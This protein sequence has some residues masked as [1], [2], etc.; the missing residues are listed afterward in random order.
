MGEMLLRWLASFGASCYIIA[1]IVVLPAWMV[2]WRV[3]PAAWWAV[4]LVA[5]VIVLG[6]LISL[7]LW[8]FLWRAGAGEQPYHPSRLLGLTALGLLPVFGFLVIPIGCW[9]SIPAPAGT[10]AGWG[11]FAASAIAL[12]MFWAYSRYAKR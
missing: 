5:E 10:I 6:A 1:A 8:W 12:I 11:I 9:V 3:A 4:Y 7:A 2:R